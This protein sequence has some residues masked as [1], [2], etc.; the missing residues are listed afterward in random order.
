MVG[1]ERERRGGEG[2]RG[3]GGRGGEGEREGGEW[4]AVCYSYAVSLLTVFTAGHTL[5][6]QPTR[7]SLG[8][9]LNKALCTVYVY[10]MLVWSHSP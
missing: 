9:G 7:H 6:G 4:K 1:R 8:R 3:G 5:F 2:D 10:C